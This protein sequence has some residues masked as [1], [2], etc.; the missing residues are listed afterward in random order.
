MASEN[1]DAF[2]IHGW[3]HHQGSWILH[4]WCEIGEAV[5]DLTETREPIDKDTYYRV[6]G[7][8]PERSI[9][10]ER[11]VFFELAAKQGHFGPF[12]RELFFAETSSTDPLVHIHKKNERCSTY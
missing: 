4:A 6:M 10:Y 8:S 5:I 2:V 1:G 7:I 3:L 12:D 9:R 11:N